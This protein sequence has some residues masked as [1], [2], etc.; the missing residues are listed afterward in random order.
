MSWTPF[1]M[2]LACVVP[3]GGVGGW[4][5]TSYHRLVSAGRGSVVMISMLVNRPRRALV[6]E[7]H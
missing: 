3:S 4:F 6:P 5:R 2:W 7:V 1:M